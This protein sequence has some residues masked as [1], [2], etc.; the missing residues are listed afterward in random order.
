MKLE[1]WELLSYIVTVFGF[2]LAIFA[3]MIEQR[4]ER[5]NEDEEVY[6]LLTA[7]YT[8]FLKLVMANPDLQLRSNCEITSLTEE[9]QERKLVIFEIL[10]S[11]FERAYLLSYDEKM[12][13]KQ[14]R[15]WRSWEDF[16]SEWCER[17][18]FRKILPRLLQ[19][20]D[21]DFA[22][23]IKQLAAKFSA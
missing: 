19:G 2:P 15:R 13:N 21:P 10:I 9:Q 4:K 17:E 7:D 16:M 6:Q 8:D 22:A 18:D 3:F 11:L 23:H 20:E 5:E 14:L 1:T 12:S